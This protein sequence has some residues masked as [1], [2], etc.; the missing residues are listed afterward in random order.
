MTTTPT[1]L[2][3]TAYH[4]HASC[5]FTGL[6]DGTGVVLHLDRR[7]YVTLNASAV[8][9]RRRLADRAVVAGK[10]TAAG[11]ARHL[12]RVFAVDD[13]TARREVEVLLAELVRQELVL[14]ARG[15]DHR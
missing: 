12:T 6:S 11:L 4:C 7:R 3:T 2:T 13:D 8:V 15:S 5:R 9:V 10:K 14:P 1:P